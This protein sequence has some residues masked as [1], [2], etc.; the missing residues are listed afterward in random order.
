ML[1]RIQLKNTSGSVINPATNEDLAE[2]LNRFENPFNTA[3][4]Q[5]ITSESE[6]FWARLAREGRPRNAIKQGTSITIGTFLST[7]LIK[8]SLGC[9]FFPQKITVSAT[10]DAKLYIAII[11]GIRDAEDQL[12]I[13]N[14]PAGQKFEWE[15]NGAFSCVYNSDSTLCGRVELRAYTTN[16]PLHNTSQAGNTVSGSK[17]ISDLTYTTSLMKGMTVT[18]TGIPS[19]TTILDILDSKSILI[20]ANATV[21]GTG[22]TLTFTDTAAGL[23]GAAAGIEVPQNA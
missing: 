3:E 23:W 2:L 8:P 5:L 20:S 9:R 18:G 10:V 16:T 15:P 7:V 22:I 19:N 11:T 21:G 1:N 17:I 4:G 12:L 14:C 6:N 13:A